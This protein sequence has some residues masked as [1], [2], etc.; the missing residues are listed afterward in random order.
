[1]LFMFVA[2]AGF[3]SCNDDG[4]ENDAPYTARLVGSWQ[5]S[6]S[7][8]E[9]SI[10]SN[11]RFDRNSSFVYSFSSMHLD[12]ITVRAWSVRG[13]WNVRKGV[14]QLS[15]D[16]ET[17]RA[18]GYS[19]K[20]VKEMEADLRDSNLLLSEMNQNGRPFGPTISFLDIDGKEMLR[21]SDENGYYERVGN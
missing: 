16:L 2:L 18:E 3:V 14:L 7:N 9:L 8:D 21:F 1:M 19:E 5:M 15:Y 17:F 4:T 6:N 12:D 13:A 10:Q 20:E 11:Y